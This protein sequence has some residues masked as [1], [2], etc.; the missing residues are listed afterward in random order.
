W[1][2]ADA[3]LVPRT[4]RRQRDENP[5]NTASFSLALLFSRIL[6][7]QSASRMESGWRTAVL[8]PPIVLTIRTNR[9]ELLAAIKE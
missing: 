4:S 5:E 6:N 7:Q 9:M 2:N 8:W 3:R 1:S